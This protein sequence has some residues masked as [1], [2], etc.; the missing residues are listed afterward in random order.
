MVY[1]FVLGA[2]AAQNGVLRVT[3]PTGVKIVLK[4]LD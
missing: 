4:K 1:G 3:V 2:A